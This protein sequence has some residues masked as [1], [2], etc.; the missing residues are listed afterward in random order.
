MER[1]ILSWNMCKKA[2]INTVKE[3]R[4]LGVMLVCKREIKKNK[5]IKKSC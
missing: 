1:L 5:K 3:I 4:I 2:L